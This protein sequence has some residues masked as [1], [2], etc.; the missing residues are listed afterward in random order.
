MNN[1]F[2]AV[3]MAFRYK[4]SIV[5]SIVLSAIVA[6]FWGVNIT[7]VYPFVE[8]V[9]QNKT[10]HDWIDERIEQAEAN[11]NPDTLEH[12]SGERLALAKDLI[13]QYAPHDPFT[14]LVYIVAFLIVGTFL[15]SVCR[16]G[17]TVLVSRVAGRTTL[18]LRNAFFRGAL[19]E[20]VET[21]RQPSEAAARVGGD[22]GSIGGAI[23]TLFGRS[24]Q[25]PLK[26]GVCLTGAAMVNWRLLLFSL[27]VCP[28]ASLLLLSL[29]KLIRRASLRAF[30]QKCLLMGRMLQTFQGLH[31]VKAYNMESYERRRFWTHTYRVYREQLK[32]TWY[33][34]LIRSNNELLGIGVICLS[35]LAGGYLVLEQTTQMFGFSLA[36]S[37][38]D[39]GQIMLFYALLIGCTD[40]LRKMADVYGNIQNGAAAAD[41]I[42][43]FVSTANATDES[44]KIRIRDARTAITFEDVHFQ[45]IRKTPVL[46]GVSFR[47]EQGETLAIIGPNGSGKSTLINLLLCFN[48]PSKGRI[49][50]GD[51]DLS[52]IRRKNFRRRTALV[53]QKPVL[54]NESV[55]KNIAYGT[56]HAT[57]EE[58]EEAARRAHADGFIRRQLPEGYDSPC[59]DGGKRL[60]GGQQQRIVLA[61]AILRD[62]D[63]LILD[64]AASQI[65]PTSELLIRKSLAE[66]S[67]HRTTII[68]THRIASLEH[69]DRVL[70]MDGGRVV[71]LGTHQEL[72]N[73]CPL[74]RTLHDDLHRKSA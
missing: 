33:E 35:A 53:T 68:I 22:M 46:N 17:S 29:A 60:S 19:A 38:P 48:S 50:L 41:R 65:D 2:K 20:R 51:I 58:V 16:I 61:R 4:Y 71:D 6:V 34:G 10:L 31:V 42:I 15:K 3:R 12:V 57:H 25:E 36:A 52:T 8:V 23:R 49:L 74:F 24:V 39:F 55:Y 64:E 70:V 32:M 63:I 9:F 26:M 43:P 30:D 44:Q 67:R 5:G 7:A 28:L 18:D 40:P 13:D 59:G 37:V 66:F 27:L 72:M 62:P 56:R 73:R 47:V 45:Y 1:L 54:F 21:L 69:A 14:T 11:S